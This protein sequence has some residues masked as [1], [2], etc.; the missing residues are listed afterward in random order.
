MA[1]ET[2]RHRSRRQFHEDGWNDN[3]SRPGQVSDATRALLFADAQQ[4]EDDLTVEM[5][6]LGHE[7]GDPAWVGLGRG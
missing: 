6:L 7:D 1:T 2:S 5:E 3:V 4:R